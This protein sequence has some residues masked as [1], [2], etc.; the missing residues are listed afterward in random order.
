MPSRSRS[1][2]RGRTRSRSID[3]SDS[4][5]PPLRSR[6]PSSR[7]ARN[8]DRRTRSRSP[9]R[10]DDSRDS[11]EFRSQS[12]DR[13]TRSRSRSARGDDQILKSTKI[14]VEKLT[15][16]VNEDHLRE[17]FGEYGEIEDLDLP[18]NR[19]CELSTLAFARSPQSQAGRSAQGW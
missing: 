3:R 18:M 9:I 12:Y 8:G 15:K 11:W 10:R 6:T 19:Q 5:S 14:V 16:N 13:R 2:S 1:R 17:I 7:G 4:R